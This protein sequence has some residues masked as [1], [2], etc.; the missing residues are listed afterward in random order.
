MNEFLMG[1]CSYLALQ[2]QQGNNA[3]HQA[4]KAGYYQSPLKSYI[5]SEQSYYEKEG[6][7]LY[8]SLPLHTPLSAASLLTYNLYKREFKIPIDS[9]INLEYNNTSY[10]CNLTWGF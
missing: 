5:D 8:Y 1:L 4:I 7:A 3:C 6:T 10:A 9:H 2:T